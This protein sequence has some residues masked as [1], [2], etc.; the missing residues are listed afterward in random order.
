MS[1]RFSDAWLEELRARLSIEEIVSE[2][3]RLKP[4]G[5][6]CWGLCPFHNEKTPSFS[7]DTQTQLFY[8]FGCH[9]GGTVIQFVME[10]ERLDFQEAV[11]LLAERAHLPLP[12]EAKE[13]GAALRPDERERIY[14]ANVAAARFFHATLW[15]DE[16]AQGLSY[17]YKR[18]LSDADIRRFG[19]GFAP[20]GWDG[21]LRHLAGEGFDQA[22][23]E[24]AGLVVRREGGAYDM[25]RGRVIFP[26]INAQGKV[27]GFG[28]RALGEAQPKYLN[29]ADTPVFNKRQGLY[30]LNFVKKERGV[31]RLVL[32]EGYM[33]AV[34]LRKHGVQGVVATL[35]TAL[36]EEQARLMKRYAPE[37][38]ISYDGD[39]AG[40]KAALR[41]L[42]ILAPTG[43]KA[44]VID[45]PEGMDPDEFIRARGAAGFEALKKYDAAEYRMLRAR[46]G[47]DLA[48]QEGTTQYALRC[49]QILRGVQNPV[50]ME[51]HLRRLVAETGY[52]REI[53]LQQIGVSAPAREE[54][55]RALRPRGS[56]GENASAAE[57]ALLTLLSEGR[58]PAQTV[59]PGDFDAG[60]LRDCAAWLIEGKSVNAF[61]ERLDDE[62]RARVLPAL[63]YQPLPESRDEA[64]KMAED[65][66]N[67]IRGA[68]RAGE[69]ERLQAQAATADAEERRRIY[70]KIEKLY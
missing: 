1:A 33:D 37:V 64:L 41:A 29:T 46:D 35:G 3:V 62:A 69:V 70:E 49:C 56:T 21:T 61:L 20:R 14:N 9:K 39:A 19:L 65:A 54:R 4:K 8:C 16:G 2:Y 63:N 7:V 13:K 58:I 52:D 38:W 10:M 67:A 6:R 26:I 50:E 59:D 53:L 45:Y 51:N 25:F 32:V 44:R 15:T 22:I 68:R 42:D 28:G 18:G 23:L 57:R 48:T 17:L 55:P 66:L 34:S 47:L 43:L 12:A 36:T 31:G 27:L 30:A 60:P 5:H 11:K 40:Q 24:R